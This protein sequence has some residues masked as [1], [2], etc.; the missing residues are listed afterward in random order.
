MA[1][2]DY[3]ETLA[4][5]EAEHFWFRSR[6]RLL[7]WALDRYFPHAGS[8]LEIG[9]RAGNV[10]KAFHDAFPHLPLAGS[11]IEGE[12]LI[13]ARRR[14][15]GIPLVR[16]DAR[17]LPFRREA[18][19]VIGM[20]DVLEH[21]DEDD[22]VLRQ[23]F[24]ATRPGGGLI[25]T[26]PQHRFLWSVV[27]AH[28]GHCRRYRRAELLAK[29]RRCGFVVVRATSF[30]TALLPLAWIS[31]VMQN[32]RGLRVD[33]EFEIHRVLNGALERVMDVERLLIRTGVSLPAGVSLLV[34]ARR[35]AEAAQT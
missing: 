24:A 32:R 21:I 14:L 29:I 27:D 9:C 31:R 17:Q 33:A 18:F 8:L 28:S 6:D 12:S 23:I 5:L 2:T 35:Q 10:L 25:L 11:E 16:M 15:P 1:D 30:V 26:V 20:F 7:V 4:R 13:H 3:F 34:V 19:D 22:E